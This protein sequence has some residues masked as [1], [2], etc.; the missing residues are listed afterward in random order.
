MAMAMAMGDQN[1]HVR[2]YGVCVRPI[3]MMTLETSEGG[4]RM[5]GKTIEV[6]GQSTQGWL[7]FAQLLVRSFE[8]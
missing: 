6:E 1:R 4:N 8:S 2:E 3:K 7:P 5:D